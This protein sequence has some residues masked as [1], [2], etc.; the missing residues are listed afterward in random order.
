MHGKFIV[1][2]GPDGAGTTSHAQLLEENLRAQG[3]AT[4]LTAEPTPG[5]IGKWIRVLLKGEEPM[6]S[7]A[8]QILFCADRAW[9]IQHDIKPALEAG[10]TV[11]CD[12]YAL[13][14][15]VYGSALGH[16]AAWL[17]AINDGFLKPDLL[18]LT[19]PPYETCLERVSRR[20][21]NDIFEEPKLM[22]TIYDG[23]RSYAD[24]HPHV[25][26]VDTSGSKENTAAAILA[27]TQ[28]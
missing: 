17:T 5:P 15:I 20:S 23:Y 26:V 6:P 24:T 18:I 28:A 14:T 7:D 25:H 3:I 11:I 22:R 19:L 13:S 1:I 2:E 8:L 9:H 4:L 12:R 21:E 16:D 27:L 10:K